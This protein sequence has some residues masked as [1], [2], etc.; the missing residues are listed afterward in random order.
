[1]KKFNNLIIGKDKRE[2]T[3]QK[4]SVARFEFVNCLPPNAAGYEHI[5]SRFPIRLRPER[6][7]ERITARHFCAD[8]I[9]PKISYLFFPMSI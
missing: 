9:S 2:N 1:M 6:C 4:L 7:N 8:F 5:R 3:K